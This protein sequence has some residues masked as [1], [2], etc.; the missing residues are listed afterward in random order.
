M[1]AVAPSDGLNDEIETSQ[2]LAGLYQ[3]E[4]LNVICILNRSGSG[5][6]S[7]FDD[8]FARASHS[9]IIRPAQEL[10]DEIIQIAAIP[11]AQDVKHIEDGIMLR[12]AVDKGV[13]P[14]P[15]P[16]R[17]Q[18]TQWGAGGCGRP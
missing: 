5:T 11:H 14:K 18:L 10:A 8:N 16:E 13:D 15:S 1:T 7:N 17:C 2:T 6:P 9:P 12:V 4:D 3:A